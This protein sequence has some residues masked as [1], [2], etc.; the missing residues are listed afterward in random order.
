MH[1]LAQM[2]NQFP[3]LPILYQ[4]RQNKTAKIKSTK[5]IHLSEEMPIPA[6]MQFRGRGKH[7]IEVS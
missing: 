7:I 2:L 6:I 3:V 5:L 1:Y 4:S